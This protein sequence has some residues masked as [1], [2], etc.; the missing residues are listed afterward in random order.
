MKPTN[1]WLVRHGESTGNVDKEIYKT[2]PDYALRLTQK[3]YEQALAVGKKI[4]EELK[5][6]IAFYTSSFFR[7]RDTYQG[8]IEGG[9]LDHR[10]YT[11][12]EDSRLVEQSWGQSNHTI[13]EARDAYGHYY[14]RFANGESCME[15]ENRISSFLNTL[16]RE[17]E[18]EDYPDNVVIVTHG[19]STRVFLKRF[20]KLTV[21]E[22]ELLANPENCGVYKLILGAPAGDGRFRWT[23]TSKYCCDFVK[24]YPHRNSIHNY[25]E[26][27][28]E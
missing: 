20:F 5:G 15:V 8:I 24:R 22:F 21:E 18:K 17:F 25:S 1:I 23:T 26:F 10:I 16:W 13:E 9:Q 28:Y 11:R 19:M 14:F 3:G 27:K 6:P 7:T 12:Y 2:T 4:G